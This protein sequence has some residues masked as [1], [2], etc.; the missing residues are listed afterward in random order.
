MKI[1]IIKGRAVTVDRSAI[2][3]E[4]AEARVFFQ[5]PAGNWT[6]IFGNAGNQYYAEIK[7]GAARVPSFL[8]TR[9]AYIILSV[10]RTDVDEPEPIPC[11]PLRVRCLADSLRRQFEISGAMT[12]QDARDQLAELAE[13]MERMRAD[14]DELTQ[15]VNELQARLDD[16]Y[17]GYDPLGIGLGLKE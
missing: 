7:D 1:K 8:L 5:L 17:K 14:H 9:T 4:N 12:E 6:A 3:V 11:E 13:D 10:V 15:R 16:I 2:V